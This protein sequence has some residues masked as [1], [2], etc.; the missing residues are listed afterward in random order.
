M[1]LTFAGQS[2]C[3]VCALEKFEVSSTI[4]KPKTSVMPVQCCF[5][6]LAIIKVCAQDVHNKVWYLDYFFH[7]LVGDVLF[8]L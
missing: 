2:Q 7:I 8:M 1:I 4:F 6:S 5:I 3:L